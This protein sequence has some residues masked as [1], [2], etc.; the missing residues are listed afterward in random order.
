MRAFHYMTNIPIKS[1][2]RVNFASCLARVIRENDYQE[3]LGLPSYMD[4][5]VN[6]FN[7]YSEKSIEVEGTEYTLDTSP[8]REK[9]QVDMMSSNY[10]YM[11]VD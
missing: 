1:Y 2:D 11:V 5:Y 3:T 4:K 10:L 9:K 7:T 6:V 8:P